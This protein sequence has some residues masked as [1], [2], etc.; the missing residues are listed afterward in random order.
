MNFKSCLKAQR[1]RV[2]PSCVIQKCA[3][4]SRIYSSSEPS[5]LPVFGFTRCARAHERHVM[6]VAQ[7]IVYVCVFGC[8]QDE[9]TGAS[10]SAEGGRV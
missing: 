8:P 10:V 3:E 4:I 5:T 7:V 9:R 1:L 2:T 6:N